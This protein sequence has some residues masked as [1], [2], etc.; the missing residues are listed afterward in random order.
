MTCITPCNA[1]KRAQV[2]LLVR[3]F[4]SPCALLKFLIHRVACACVYLQTNHSHYSLTLNIH[5]TTKRTKF[6]NTN[7]WM[8]FQRTGQYLAAVSGVT[9]LVCAVLFDS[10][11]GNGLLLCHISLEFSIFLNSEIALASS[12][13]FVIFLAIFFAWGLKNN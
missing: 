11:S 1:V 4:A 13:I 3:V 8:V 5:N 6:G 10:I 9:H 2:A 7:F 12:V